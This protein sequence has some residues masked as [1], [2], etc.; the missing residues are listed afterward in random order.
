MANN[1]DYYKILGVNKNATKTEIKKA[2]KKLAVK[3][4]PDK[5]PNNKEA[6][7]KFKVISDA[8]SVLS[9][10][11]KRSKYDQFGKDGLS[12]GPNMH[13]NPNDIFNT[14]FQG[15]DPFSS[16]VF[17]FGGKFPGGG[18]VK[19]TM[20]KNGVTFTSFS[21]NIP[22]PRSKPPYPNSVNIINKSTK[23]LIINIS[24]NIFNENIGQIID[25]DMIKNRYLVKMHDN[26]QILLK[27]ENL[28]QL[29]K[30]TT[31]NL[32][33][34]ELN[35]IE[36]EIVGVCEDID[37]YKINL[38]NK[39]IALKHNNF[40]VPNGTCVE[41]INLS[42]SGFNGKKGK[43]KSF[44]LNSMRYDILLENNQQSKIKLENIKI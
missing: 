28:L 37:R 29:V 34:T 21:N 20:H 43:I 23:V 14:F 6:E 31:I 3:Y 33:K 10:N 38:N 22:V 32:T 11:E 27:H 26:K 39:I 40:I 42:T 41:L 36:G 9:D 12:N 24:N 18:N 1:D 15:Q 2:Y 16:G 5:N 44:D 25:Y 7:E 35:N 13:G 17:P 19:R 30:I 8:Y 4:H